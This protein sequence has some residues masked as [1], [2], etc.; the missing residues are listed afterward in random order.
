MASET[1]I[2]DEKQFDVL[3]DEL[4]EAYPPATTDPVTFLGAQFD[5]GLAWPHFPVGYGGLGAS[6]ARFTQT[7]RSPNVPAPATSQPLAE[8][9]QISSTSSP[10][11]SLRWDRRNAATSGR[12][13]PTEGRAR[14]RP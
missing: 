7:V 6:P 5:R 2:L 12:T 1:E 11:P 9:R 13:W 4:L 10:R 3:I 14:S 8:I